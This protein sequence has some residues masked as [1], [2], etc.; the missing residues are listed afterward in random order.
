MVLCHVVYGK[1]V[2]IVKSHGCKVKNGNGDERER[3]P[4]YRITDGYIARQVDGIRN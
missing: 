2:I 3:K 1:K 4:I